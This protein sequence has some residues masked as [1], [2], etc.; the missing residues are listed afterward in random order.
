MTWLSPVGLILEFIAFWFATPELL[1]QERLKRLEGK[2]ESLLE[3]ILRTS[4]RFMASYIEHDNRPRA[5]RARRRLE[6]GTLEHMKTGDLEALGGIEGLASKGEMDR[7]QRLWLGGLG[8]LVS[9][10]LLAVSRSM[11]RSVTSFEGARCLSAFVGVGLLP[12]AMLGLAASAGMLLPDLLRKLADDREL[13]WRSLLVGAILFVLGITLQFVAPGYSVNRA[14]LLVELVAAFLVGPEVLSRKRL[15]NLALRRMLQIG[16]GLFI[17][18]TVLQLVKQSGFSSLVGAGLEF[19][20]F[21]FT[22]PTVFGEDWLDEHKRHNLLIAGAG[23]LALA[24][25]MQFVATF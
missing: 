14:G 22:V 25:L 18:G 5:R 9:V 20:S 17:F 1:G 21:W 4:Y 3:R 24:V 2:L 12:T 11:L 6:A 23:I 15:S 19:F 13:R 7:K 10:I 16:V 8:L